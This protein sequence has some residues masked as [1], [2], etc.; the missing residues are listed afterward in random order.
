MRVRSVLLASLTDHCPGKA[1]HCRR[2]SRLPRRPVERGHLFTLAPVPVGRK[3]YFTS[4]HRRRWT[5]PAQA[6]SAG[7]YTPIFVFQA[8]PAFRIFL[9]I[10]VC[11]R[12]VEAALVL[13][14]W[15]VHACVC[16]L[17]QD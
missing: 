13:G 10:A 16:V 11:G 1:D 17:N 5:A 7:K 2:Y 3:G 9:A 6:S 14:D 15:V 12:F 4:Q 8:V